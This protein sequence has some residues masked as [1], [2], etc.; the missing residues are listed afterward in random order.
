MP[1]QDEAVGNSGGSPKRFRRANRS[2][3]YRN[4]RLMEPS[5][6]WFPL[7]KYMAAVLPAH[8]NATVAS[9]FPTPTLLI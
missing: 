7:K 6:N 8:D 9:N 1:Q 4:E 3:R 5:G 2:S